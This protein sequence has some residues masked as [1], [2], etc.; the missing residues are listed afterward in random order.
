MRA[1][2]ATATQ[3]E[4]TTAATLGMWVF[5][6]TEVLFFSVLFFGYAM[7]RL[8][9]PQAFAAASRR[10]DIVLG[11]VNTAVLLTSS[12][13]VALA[14]RSLKLGRRRVSGWL[15]GTTLALGS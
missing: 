8:H 4:D 10:T 14:V 3:A 5:L 7:T 15:L 11:T 9:Y 12:L 13:C 1:Q 2:L 6:A